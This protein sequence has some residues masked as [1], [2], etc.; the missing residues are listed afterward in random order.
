MMSSGNGGR[1]K[2]IQKVKPLGRKKKFGDVL[3]ATISFK[4]PADQR[5]DIMARN[6]KWECLEA[7]MNLADSGENLENVEKIPRT[8]SPTDSDSKI[9]E[10]VIKMIKPFALKK[11]K[12]NMTPEEQNIIKELAKEVKW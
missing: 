11:I 12:V 2:K 3:G 1:T 9:R 4:V 6:D 7:G 5:E 8:T 10:I